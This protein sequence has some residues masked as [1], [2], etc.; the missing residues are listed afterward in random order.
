M[1]TPTKLVHDIVPKDSA[2][3][4]S[5]A[6]RNVDHG[7]L[8]GRALMSHAHFDIH[9]WDGIDHLETKTSIMDAGASGAA[10]RATARA[11]GERRRAPRHGAPRPPA[12]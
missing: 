9:A 7:C 10:V 1:C 11:G 8:Y 4:T 3:L 5:V 6:N 12:P 2:V